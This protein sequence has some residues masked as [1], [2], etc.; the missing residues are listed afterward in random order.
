MLDIKNRLTIRSRR[1]INYNHDGA[2]LLNEALRIAA[3][4]AAELL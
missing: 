4:I 1:C 3:D 2:K